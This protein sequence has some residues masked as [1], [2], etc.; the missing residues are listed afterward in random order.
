MFKH[1]VVSA[2]MFSVLSGILL[3][4]AISESQVY[5]PKE[6]DDYPKAYYDRI[7]MDKTAFQFQ[8]AW[9]QKAERASRNRKPIPGAMSYYDHGF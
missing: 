1:L 2:I 4:P 9:I 8:K 3:V 5:P 7:R 6:G